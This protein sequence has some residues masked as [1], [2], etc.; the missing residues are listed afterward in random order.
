MIQKLL[1][2]LFCSLWSIPLVAQSDAEQK[3]TLPNKSLKFDLN[4]DGSH[5]LKA[6]FTAQIWA[7]YNQSNPGTTIYGYEKSETFDIGL[8]RVR[9]VID[10]MLTDKVYLFTQFGINNFTSTSQRKMPLFFHDVVGE[11]HITQR[12]LHIGGGLTGFTGMA[13]FSS[14]SIGT[15]MGYDAPLNQQSTND[16]TDQFLRKLSIYA[17]GK[18]GR[19]DYRLIASNPMSAQNSTVV[20]DI[21]TNANFSLKPPSMQYSGYFMYQFYDEESNLTPYTV[22]TYLGKKKVFN[23]GVGF[24]YQANAMWRWNNT[25]QK[26]TI[27]EDMLHLA[28][29]VFYDKPVGSKGAALSLYAAYINYNYGKGYLRNIG[30]MNPATG[31]TATSNSLN[32]GGNGV[33]MLGTGSVLQGQIGYLLPQ[34]VLGE[35]KGQLMPYIMVMSANYDRLNQNMLL[36]DAGINWFITGHKTKISLDWQNRPVFRATDQK[37]AERKSMAVVQFQLS[38]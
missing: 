38:F 14:P 12:S 11:Y 21:N 13:R 25:L 36:Y 16:A 24:Q 29:D 7:R 28:A 27:S 2:A 23:I 22:G 37:V 6:S 32:G 10:G 8:R 31:T 3:K 19:L 30:V 4:E 5:Y 15:I 18:L 17:K 35:E 26:D 34:Y 20:Q 1:I 33:A 9:T